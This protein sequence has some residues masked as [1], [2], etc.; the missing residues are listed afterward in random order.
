MHDR[1]GAS[2]RQVDDDVIDRVVAELDDPGDDEHPDVA[3]EHESGWGLSAFQ[4]GLLVWEDVEDGGEP[5]HMK[6]VSRARVRELFRRVA[7]GDLESIEAEPWLPG[8]R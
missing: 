6:D 7:D 2:H 5:R 8:Y 1:T 3:I 4:T